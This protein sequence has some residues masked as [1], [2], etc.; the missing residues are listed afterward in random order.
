MLAGV[1]EGV[2]VLQHPPQKEEK[3]KRKGKIRKVLKG[4]EFWLKGK[5]WSEVI[6]R[7]G[8][9]IIETRRSPLKIRC[10]RDFAC[11]VRGGFEEVS[12]VLKASRSIPF[13]FGFVRSSRT[14]CAWYA[15]VKEAEIRR[16][17]PEFCQSSKESKARHGDASKLDGFDLCC[18]EGRKR[19]GED[20]F[21]W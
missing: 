12:V 10:S 21:F 13:V 17:L 3:L 4:E 16:R 14:S 2:R 1:V 18:R 9:E 19:K 8:G 20:I 15:L 6:V 11:K 5:M 7:R